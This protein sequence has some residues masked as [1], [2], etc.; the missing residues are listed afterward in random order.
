[1]SDGLDQLFFKY[2]SKNLKEILNEK[3]FITYCAPYISYTVKTDSAYKI[4][5][6]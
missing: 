1:M 3:L 5:S 4:D 2:K 6:H